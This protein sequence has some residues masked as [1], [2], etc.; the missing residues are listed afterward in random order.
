MKTKKKLYRV[1]LPWDGG[2]DAGDYQDSVWAKDAETAIRYVAS[3]MADSCAGVMTSKERKAFIKERI[4]EASGYAA[5]DVA[6]GVANDIGLLLAGPS[7]APLSKDAEAAKHT[8][9]H[10]LAVFSKEAA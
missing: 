9:L 4:A 8:I 2:D 5:E 1:T 7:G 10:L 3:L 6:E